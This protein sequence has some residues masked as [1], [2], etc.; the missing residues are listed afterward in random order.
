MAMTVLIATF[1]YG[2]MH[3]VKAMRYEWESFEVPIAEI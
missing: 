3:N 2:G 1:T